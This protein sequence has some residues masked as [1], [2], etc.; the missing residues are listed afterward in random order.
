MLQVKFLGFDEGVVRL[1][2]KN[3]R[4]FEEA[5]DQLDCIFQQVSYVSTTSQT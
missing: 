4:Y 1:L 3:L 5:R 2:N